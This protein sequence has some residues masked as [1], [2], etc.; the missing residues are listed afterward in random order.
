MRRKRVQTKARARARHARTILFNDGRDHRVFSL[1]NAGV[2][3]AC[4]GVLRFTP[5]PV[6]CPRPSHLTRTIRR[7]RHEESLIL[8]QR[9]PVHGP[10]MLLQGGHQHALPRP[11]IRPPRAVLVRLLRRGYRRDG[12]RRTRT[13]P[14]RARRHRGRA[15]RSPASSST[16][17]SASTA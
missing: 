4:D 9:Q 3:Q 7:C 1:D 13:R 8:R 14:S 16:C 2:P 10:R 6:A 17:S 12:G 15:T 5:P 11:P